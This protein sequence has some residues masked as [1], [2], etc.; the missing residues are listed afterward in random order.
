MTYFIAP[1]A[2][3]YSVLFIGILVTIASVGIAAQS[4]TT[5]AGSPAT[6]PDNRVVRVAAALGAALIVLGITPLLWAPV[7]S[8]AAGAGL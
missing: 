3:A 6:V 5:S 8:F 2:L 1:S 4:A 7:Q